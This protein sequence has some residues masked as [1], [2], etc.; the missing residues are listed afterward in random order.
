MCSLFVKSFYYALNF[1]YY[2][3]DF[4]NYASLLND[5]KYASIHACVTRHG[6]SQ[7][8][9]P[10]ELRP[11]GYYLPLKINFILGQKLLPMG[12]NFPCTGTPVM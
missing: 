5:T 7:T 3:Q 10:W 8:V 11:Y 6:I 9:A 4:K 2:A 1:T 12:K